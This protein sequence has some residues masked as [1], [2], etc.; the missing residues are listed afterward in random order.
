MG[1]APSSYGRRVGARRA[2]G[3]GV[4]RAQSDAALARAAAARRRAGGAEGRRRLPHCNVRAR[5]E[6]EEAGVARAT[7]WGG[8]FL[9]AVLVGRVTRAERCGVDRAAF[10][11]PRAIGG[12]SLIHISEP[13]RRS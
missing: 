2:A 6:G 1:R 3:G 7:D 8:G 10:K 13:T 9:D 4:A 11:D 5:R 12:L